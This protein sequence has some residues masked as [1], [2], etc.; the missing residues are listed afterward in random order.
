MTPDEKHQ[1]RRSLAAAIFD[2]P[3]PR[4]G[5]GDCVCRECGCWDWNACVDARDGPC[6]WVEQ[7]LCSVC[8]SRLQ[9]RAHP[10]Y[11]GLYSE[12]GP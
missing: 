8:A 6:W 1:L 9:A 7:N 10:A 4:P 5:P 3:P 12:D 11:T 2:P